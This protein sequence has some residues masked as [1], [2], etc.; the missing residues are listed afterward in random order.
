[1]VCLS[2]DATLRS[3]A[4]TVALPPGA[5]VFLGA[6]EPSVEVTGDGEV[7]QASPGAC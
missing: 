5:A 7:F 6:E 2:G 3:G 4:A 1:V